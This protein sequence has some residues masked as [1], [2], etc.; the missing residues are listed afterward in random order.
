[1]DESD[2]DSKSEGVTEPVESATTVESVQDSQYW[3]DKR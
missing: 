3:L 1:M 2:S